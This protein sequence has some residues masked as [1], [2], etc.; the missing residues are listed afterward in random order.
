MAKKFGYKKY[1]K[2]KEQKKDLSTLKVF[3]CSFVLMLVVF[4]V[5]INCFAPDVDVSIGD[6]T[7]E[8]IE[9]E[10]PIYLK[11]YVDDRLLA[12]QQEDLGQETRKLSTSEKAA[13]II[14]S[15][16]A[17]EPKEMKPVELEITVPEINITQPKDVVKNI[18]APVPVA[19]IPPVVQHP[20]TP[21]EVSAT[22]RVYIGHYS[23]YDQVKIAKDIVNETD[24]TLNA[25]IKQVS[26]GYTLQAGV[27]KNKDAATTLTNNLLKEHLPAR[28][29]IE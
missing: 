3:A 18:T 5:L 12:I 25:V 17:P 27:F 10:T 19:P 22:Y 15:A 28:M 16:S 6:A 24:P 26:N 21:V 20:Q 23:T 1:L 9:E 29:I 14:E 8:N 11:K 7:S 2:P 4:T 13:K